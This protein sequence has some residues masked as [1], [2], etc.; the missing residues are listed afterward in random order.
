MARRFSRMALSTRVWLVMMVVVLG[1]AALC[2]LSSIDSRAQQMKSLS[3]SLS[4]E[5]ETAI[6]VIESFRERSAH[7]EFDEATA[8]RLALAE[9]GS[10]RWDGGTGYLFVFDSN[11]VLREHPL[12]GDDVGKSIAG[13]TDAHGFHHYRALLE[14][15]L[16]DG[17]AQVRYTQLIPKTGEARDKIGVSRWYKP[18]DLHVVTGAYFQDIDQ[19]FRQHLVS[20]LSTAAMVGLIVVLMVWLSLRSIRRTLGG[21]PHEAVAMASRIA[22]G[23]LRS[24]D[25]PRYA[26][27]SLLGGLERMRAQLAL[28]VTGVQGSARTVSHAAVQL[29]DSNESLS[30]RTQ[31]QASSLEESAASMEEMTAAVKQ[32]AE[33]AGV[34]DRIAR[35]ARQRAE[36]GGRIAGE[37]IGAMVA[38]AD[39]SKQ[40]EDIVNLIDTIAFQ[41]NLLALNAGVEAARAGEHGR[42]FAVVASEVRRLAHSSASAS[43][44]IKA[45]I[46][47]SAERVG[48]GRGLVQQT[49]DALGAI[50]TSVRKLTDIVGEVSVASRE[51]SAGVDQVNLAIAQIDQVTQENAA[52]VEEAAAVAKLMESQALSLSESVSVFSLSA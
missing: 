1:L 10:M 51:Q 49:A 33:A 24:D 12:R 4:R 48:T 21:E 28:I 38:I 32:N 52:L 11:L 8:R 2:A 47:E 16:K 25:T 41:T 19:A 18:W 3:I 39:S 37:A 46:G 30:S 29:N 22:N 23:D 43:K 6:A 17:A 13:D 5:V 50:V 26:P 42:G 44:Q 36:D 14:G 34:A 31:S 27:D 7:G 35:E 45:L 9:V 15:D 40:I 20:S